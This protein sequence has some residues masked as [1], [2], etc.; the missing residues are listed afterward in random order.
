MTTVN[1]AACAC[2]IAAMTVLAG[3]AGSPSALDG[4]RTWVEQPKPTMS[5]RLRRNAHCFATKDP[6]NV[7]LLPGVAIVDRRGTRP[8]N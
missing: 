2:C 4:G 8:R 6:S 3:C 5:C 1:L 7:T